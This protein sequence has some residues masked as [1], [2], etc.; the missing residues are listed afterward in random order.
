MNKI[1]KARNSMLF[2]SNVRILQKAANGN[3]LTDLA[4]KNRVLRDYGVYSYIRFLL[5]SFDNGSIWD[6]QQYVPKYLAVG[7]NQQP[8]TGA[9]GTDTVVK[10]TDT[11]LFHELDDSA[12]TGELPE[13]NRIKLNRGNYVE[14]NTEDGYI[15]IQYEA[16]IPEDRFVGETIGELA[17]MTQKTGWYAYARVSG[18]PSF[19]KEPNSVIQVIWEIT[20]TSIESSDR[21]TA[22]DKKYL[23]ESTEKA[24]NIL[25]VYNTD[26]EGLEGARLALEKLIEPATN[27]GTGLYYLLNDNNLITQD[28]INNYLSKPFNNLDDTGLI[29]LIN[30]F[31]PDWHPSGYIIE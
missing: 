28:D 29:A 13:N 20:V 17:L 2:Q 30:K 24:I 10:F 19:I 12:V 16:Y 23:R 26:P 11:S 5:G 25:Y 22:L 8:L 6:K 3:L 18:F 27:V 15:K 31:D 7:S 21:Y 9:P 4:I 14:D 1:L